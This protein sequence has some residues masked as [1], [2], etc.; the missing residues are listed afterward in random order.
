MSGPASAWQPVAGRKSNKNTMIAPDGEQGWLTPL[1]PSVSDRR[2]WFFR[3]RCGEQV[4][5]QATGI[6]R[7]VREGGVPKC[8]AC[9]QKAK[10]TSK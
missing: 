10:E 1:R 8:D 6:R 5:R 3:C 9:N 4:L 2:F 7:V